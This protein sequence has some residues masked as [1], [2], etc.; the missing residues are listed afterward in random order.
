MGKRLAAF[1]LT[2]A[3]TMTATCTAWASGPFEPWSNVNGY[4]I[5]A[6][7]K[8]VI[9]G[10]IERGMT[11]GKYQN[12]TGK[13]NWKQIA[14]DHISFVM[15]RLGLMNDKDEFFDLNMNNAEEAGLGLGVIFYGE[16]ATK[17]AAE[18]EAAYVLDQVKDYRVTYPIGYSLS[19][20]LLPGQSLSKRQVADLVNSFSKV[21]EDAGYRAALFGDH[22]WLTKSVDLSRV[23]SDIWYNRF[24]MAHEF[25]GRTIWRCTE[26]GHVNGV[27]GNVCI[28]FSFEDYTISFD[29]NCWR[30]INGQDYYFSDYKMVKNTSLMVD[31]GLYYFDRNGH[32]RL[33]R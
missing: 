18:Q 33:L 5:S 23:S 17:E 31:D 4:W 27:P 10:V 6:D 7:G 2:V 22:D 19:P 14:G 3:M 26:T 12:K 25:P 11:I 20:H 30:T 9:R 21:I 32:S 24:G 1:W 15:V 16:A 8:S 13:L 28:E 29:G